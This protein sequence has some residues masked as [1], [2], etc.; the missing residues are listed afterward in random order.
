M[1]NVYE[2]VPQF[3]S[4]KWVLRFVEKTDALD[5]LSVY[6]DKNAL[7]YFNSDN[8]H[9]DNFYYPDLARME[10]AIDFWLYSYKEKFFVR[11]TIVDKAENKAVGTIELFKRE[12]NDFFNDCAVLRLD[13]KNNLEK[14]TYIE[15]IANLIEKTYHLFNAKKI[16]TKIP[17]YAIERQS[18]FE[19]LGFTKSEEFLIGAD[20][21]KYRDYWTKEA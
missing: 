7:P 5:L 16:I 13:L 17:I 3:E 4:E 8:C 20:G 19:K 12:A 2:K 6:G 21:Y 11:W 14:A 9:G 15:E 10:K 1:I 18:A